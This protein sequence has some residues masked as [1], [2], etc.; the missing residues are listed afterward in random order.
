M[1]N[2]EEGMPKIPAER[3]TE[4]GQALFEAAG[5][6]PAEAALVMRHIISANLAG[7]D[8]H[9]V[10][11]IPTYIDR[12]KAGHIVPG[13]PWTIV[14]ESPATTVVDGHWGFGYVANERAMRLTIDKAKTANVAAATV[15]R[16]GH[17]G[18]VASYTLMAAEAG[19]IGL[20]TA[21]SGRSPK[22]VAPFGG[23]EAR[24]GTNPISIAIPSDLAGPLYLDMATSAAAAGKIALAVA[25]NEPVPDNWVIGNDGRP[26][27][28]PRQLRQGG[29][30]LPLGGP[31]GGYKGTGLAVMVEILCGLLTGLGFGVEPTGRHNDGCFMAVFN[32]AAFR[33]LAEFKKDVGDFIAY[34][35]ETPPAEGSSGVLYPG[36]IEYR[37]QQDRSRDGIE[38]EDATWYKLQQLADGYGLTEK[39]EFTEPE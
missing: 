7:H 13:A 31:E 5:A 30:L 6:P 38:V 20:C 11:Q 10:I 28:D 14:Q 25:R 16:Q 39:L 32:V 4:I 26:T 8:S 35:K 17:I 3:L 12:I 1:G 19:M 2:G 24:L 23:R 18:R 36:E 33:P 27:N 22:A 9:G 21:D 29:A 37:R 15:F 34:L